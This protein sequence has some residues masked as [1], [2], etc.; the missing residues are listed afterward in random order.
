MAETT[1]WGTSELVL[2]KIS[3]MFFACGDKK[4]FTL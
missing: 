3:N 4:N 2:D 1:I